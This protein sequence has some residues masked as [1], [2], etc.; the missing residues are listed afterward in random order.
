MQEG[1]E[2]LRWEKG[3]WAWAA[4]KLQREFQRVIVLPVR[5]NKKY[6]VCRILAETRGRISFVLLRDQNQG[7]LDRKLDPKESFLEAI[8]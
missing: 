7:H 5:T 1:K 2:I 4:G 8:M 6:D 3:A